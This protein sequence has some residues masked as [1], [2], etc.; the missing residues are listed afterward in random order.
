M[1][2]MGSGGTVPALD[3]VEWSASR[4]DRI[5]SVERAPSGVDGWVAS[6]SVWTLWRRGTSLSP[7]G[8]RTTNPRPSTP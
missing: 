6:E 4:P 3:G 2:R 1:R 5:T 7:A 8:N